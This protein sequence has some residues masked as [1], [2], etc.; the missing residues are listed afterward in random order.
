MDI[1]ERTF[2]AIEEGDVDAVRD[3]Y[4]SEAVIWHNFNQVEQDVEENLQVLRSMV[5]TLKERSYGDI[6]RSM[7]TSTQRKWRDSSAE[8]R[9][10]A[11]DWRATACYAPMAVAS[12]TRASCSPRGRVQHANSSRIPSGSKKYTERM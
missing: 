6:R 5:A 11:R 12:A 3:V 1:A 4:A 10:R 9:A 8:P 2:K 7:S